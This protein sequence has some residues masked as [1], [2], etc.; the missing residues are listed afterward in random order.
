MKGSKEALHRSTAKWIKE[1]EE[2]GTSLRFSE[3]GWCCEEEDGVVE[4]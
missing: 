1:E 4:I 3:E 2:T